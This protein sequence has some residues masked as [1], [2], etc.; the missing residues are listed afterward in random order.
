[1]VC[2]TLGPRN[3][4]VEFRHTYKHLG[5]LSSAWDHLRIYS[6]MLRITAQYS[7]FTVSKC[8]GRNLVG[9]PSSQCI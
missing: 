2:N 4:K 5:T 7:E 3:T 9:S 8:E 1:M 6:G